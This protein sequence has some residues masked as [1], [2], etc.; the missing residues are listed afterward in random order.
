MPSISVYSGTKGAVDSITRALAKELGP[1]GIRVN[2]VNPG[3]IET[4]GSAD[5]AHGDFADQVKSM[6]PLGRIGR[7]DDIAP[8]VAFLASD[9]AKFVTGE[10]LVA[11]GGMS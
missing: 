8:V 3:L 11:S 5:F 10:T 4:E 6:T 9:D 2:S 7:P 1:R